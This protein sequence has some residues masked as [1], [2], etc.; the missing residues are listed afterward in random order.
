[1]N[2]TVSNAPA[3]DA[4]YAPAGIRDLFLASLEDSDR[5]RAIALARH[6]TGCGN[7]L[8]SAVCAALGLAAGGTYGEGARAVLAQ[9]TG[10]K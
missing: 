6:L 5:V 9:A 3:A 7:P 10:T 8:P 1:M 4:D 2:S